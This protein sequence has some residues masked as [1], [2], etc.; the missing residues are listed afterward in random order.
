MKETR[1][2]GPEPIRTPPGRKQG[3]NRRLERG[4]DMPGKSRSFR[5]AQSP[6]MVMLTV[7]IK[8]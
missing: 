5:L 1:R 4:D 8:S 7:A 2:I 6:E 3:G